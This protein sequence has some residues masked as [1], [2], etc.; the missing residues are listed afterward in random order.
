MGFNMLL[1]DTSGNIAYYL[2]SPVPVRKDKTPYLGCRVLDGRTTKFDWVWGELVPLKDQPR[3]L[4]PK[5]GYL[6]SANGLVTTEHANTDI[7]VTMGSTP[8]H[9]RIDEIIRQGIDRG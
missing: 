6:V 5:K 9:I 2:N 8:R 1:A 3:S 7:G 4:N